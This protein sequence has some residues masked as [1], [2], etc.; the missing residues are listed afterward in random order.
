MQLFDALDRMTYI[1]KLIQQESTGS[2][3]EFALRL[4]V[5]RRQL[6]YILEGLKIK[7]AD[8]QYDRIR[9]TYYYVNDF[10]PLKADF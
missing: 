2:I 6:Y 8:I 5:C 1:H 9:R 4:H 10:D 7:G 3:D